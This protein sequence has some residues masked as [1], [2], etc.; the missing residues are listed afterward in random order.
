MFE[1]QIVIDRITSDVG[2][3]IWLGFNPA[4]HCCWSWLMG[5]TQQT[6]MARLKCW[7]SIFNFNFQ[8]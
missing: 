5:K 8:M 3:W 7:V 1:L 4:R 2:L 6:W